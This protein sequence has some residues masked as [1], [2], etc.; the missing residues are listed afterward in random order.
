MV[1]PFLTILEF[2]EWSAAV[3]AA[4][5]AEAAAEAERS[6][7]RR[8]RGDLS[9]GECGGLGGPSGR[10]GRYGMASSRLAWMDKC[11][12]RAAAVSTLAVCSSSSGAEAPPPLSPLGVCRRRSVGRNVGGVN[13]A[14]P[15]P[16][17]PL[18]VS[19]PAPA[20]AVVT[21]Q[22]HDMEIAWVRP[23]SMLS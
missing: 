12:A 5:A 20:N 14:P 1:S 15:P 11:L 2:L 13:E 6:G 9:L 8:R 3:A 17:S 23:T 4:Y 19:S 10:R 7:R 18:G 21:S 16:S 22:H